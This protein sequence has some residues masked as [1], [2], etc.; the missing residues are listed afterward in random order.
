[1]KLIQPIVYTS[2]VIGGVFSYNKIS[3]L[4]AVKIYPYLIAFI[5]LGVYW[6]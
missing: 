3:I 6:K 4:E 1:M 5:Q 2:L